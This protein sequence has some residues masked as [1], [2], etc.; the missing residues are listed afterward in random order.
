MNRAKIASQTNGKVFLREALQAE[1]KVLQ[2]QLELAN[3]SITHDG[4]MG[5]VSEQHFVDFLQRHLPK[6]YDVDQA[7]VIDSLGATSEQ[8]DIVIFD[9]QYTPTLLDQHSHR[10]VPA[11]AVYC[12]LEVKPTIDKEHLRYAGQKAASVR[13]L[14]R[15]SVAIPHAGGEYPPKPPIPIV[16]GLIASRVDWKDG[17]SSASLAENLRSQEHSFKL[18]CGLALSG[19]AFDTFD[20]ELR[21]STTSH[22]LAVFLFRLLQRLQALGTVAAVDWNGYASALESEDT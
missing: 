16:A 17:M 9:R 18:D 15:T 10:Y 21:V 6:R 8:I 5:G 3:A 1:Q 22:S 11:E 20:D 7:I 4:V 2:L 13:N 14:K 19:G 12:I